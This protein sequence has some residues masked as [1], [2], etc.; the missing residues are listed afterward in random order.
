MK[1]TAITPQKK[2]PNRYN[3]FIDNAFAFGIDGV[4]L[5]YY[6]LKEGEELTQQRYDTIM[7]E[8]VFIKAREEAMRYLDFKPRTKKEVRQKLYGEYSEQ[9]IERVVELLEK[10][11]LID[12]QNYAK[13]YIND[14][15][16][17]K[18]WGKRR[19][20][21]ELAARGISA[22]IAEPYLTDT[23]GI[24][25][26]KAEKLLEKRIKTRPVDTKEYKK[27]MDFL[28]RR[29]FDYETAKTAL[30]P[31]KSEEEI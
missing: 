24:M 18:G 4:D 17:L 6:K 13:L 12:D 28:L 16:N 25:S 9:I 31:Y 15:L 1:I 7:E 30:E 29:G 22:D 2:R 23:E 21:T 10:Y 27:H 20:L 8:L 3:V 26:K 11:K 5:L 19:I 14:C